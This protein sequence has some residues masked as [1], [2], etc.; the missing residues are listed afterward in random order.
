[1]AMRVQEGL[2]IMEADNRAGF[3]FLHTLCND[4][5]DICSNLFMADLIP[6]H[7]VFVHWML[8]WRVCSM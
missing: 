2:D 8:M 6:S 1:M 5:S 3:Q 4:R 7:V